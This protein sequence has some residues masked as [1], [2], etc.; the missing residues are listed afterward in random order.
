MT[1][2]RPALSLGTVLL[3]LSGEI[4]HAQQSDASLRVS[5][6]LGSDYKHNGLSLTNS[7]PTARFSADYE[8]PSGFFAGGFVSNV[9]FAAEDSFRK[10]R[11]YQANLYAG[12]F[13]RGTNWA[14]NVSLA[15]YLYPEL[16]V[17]YDY[18]QASVNFSFQDKFFFGATR[19]SDYLSIYRNS[20]QYRVG[21]VQPTALDLEIGL[22][23]GRFRS[24]G[25]FYTAYS[26]WD[27]GLSR[28]LGRFALDLRYHDNTYRRASLLGDSGTDRWVFSVTT[29]LLPR[30]RQPVLR[31]DWDS[32]FHQ[33]SALSH[34]R[35]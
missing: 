14:A 16:I 4:A 30:A 33:T 15:R 2:L 9:D 18:T 13:W 25:V 34:G 8:H 22:N 20:Y 21:V 5:F 28:A 26:F 12:Y 23:A 6:S 11:R 19:S 27:L 24:E 1:I 35:H 31:Q 32:L 29:A 3:L 7:D 10:P 17:S